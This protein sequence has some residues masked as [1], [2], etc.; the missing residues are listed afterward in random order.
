MLISQIRRILAWPLDLVEYVDDRF[1]ARYI[2]PFSCWI[3]P[4]RAIMS[5]TLTQAI[6]N[7]FDQEPFVVRA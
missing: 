5:F 2:E 3:D 1:Y 6:C 4:D 7:I